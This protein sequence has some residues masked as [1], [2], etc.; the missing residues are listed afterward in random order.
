MSLEHMLRDEREALRFLL[1]EEFSMDT[2]FVKIGEAVINLAHVTHIVPST[3]DNG[4]QV[5]VDFASGECFRFY[6]GKP[7]YSELQA[8]LAEQP[9]L[10]HD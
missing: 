10:L 1:G 8:W 9:T 2:Q 5:R 4:P 7:G 6:V 3:G